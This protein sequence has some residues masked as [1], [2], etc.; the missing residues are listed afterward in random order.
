MV[1]DLA[2]PHLSNLEKMVRF[3]VSTRNLTNQPLMNPLNSP[4][5]PGLLAASLCLFLASCSKDQPEA[6]LPSQ[7]LLNQQTI[8]LKEGFIDSG[9]S[10]SDTNNKS[11]THFKVSLTTNGLTRNTDQSGLWFNGS[12]GLLV[13]DFY[14][15]GSGA[16]ATGT[17]N[18]TDDTPFIQTVK[19]TYFD[20]VSN[21]NLQYHALSGTITVKKSGSE[22]VLSWDLQT[23]ENM[24]FTTVPISGSFQ[25]SLTSYQ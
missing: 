11:G 1:D 7:I 2:L 17:Y 10:F 16:P 25:N 4:G 8:A 3:L 14:S 21:G 15:T 18:A 24:N 9:T 5:L 23:Q 12:G 13:I 6:R 20:D 19:V 22:T